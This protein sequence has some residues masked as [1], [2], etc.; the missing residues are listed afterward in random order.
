M[1]LFHLK[2]SF[3][4]FVGACCLLLTVQVG[5]LPKDEVPLISVERGVKMA[6]VALNPVDE[7]L[8][9]MT[10]KQKIGQMIQ[11][12]VNKLIDADNIDARAS[13]NKPRVEALAKLGIGSLFNTPFSG[14]NGRNTW[15]PD[16]W[17]AV[18][19]DIQVIFAEN[20]ALPVIYGIDTIHGANYVHGATLFPQPLAAASSFNVDL[21]YRMGVIEAKDS[22]AAGIPWVFSPVL[23]IAM[24]PKWSRNY[25]TFGEDPHT[26]AQLGVAAIRGIQ[27]NN[28]SAACMKHFIGYSN[29]TSGNDRADSV[30]NDFELLNYYAPPFLAAISEAKVRT[31]METYVS[32]NGEPVVASHKLLTD[33]LRIDMGFQGVLT[34]DENE[35]RQLVKEHHVAS[36]YSDALYSVYNGTS[37]DMNMLSNLS[38]ATTLTEDLVKQGLLTEAR[39]DESVRRILELKYDLGLLSKPTTV[40]EPPTPVGSVEDQQEAKALADESIILLKN[41]PK[42]PVDAVN[43]KTALPIEDPHATIFLTGPLADTKAFLCGGW[44]IY[45]QGTDNS[46]LIPHGIT[47]REGLTRSYDKLQYAKGVD[48]DGNPVENRTELLEK[49]AKSSYTIVVVGEAPYAEKNGDVDDL[50]LPEGQ[51]KYVQE[52]TAIKSTNV[53]LVIV[54]GRPRLLGGITTHAAAVLLSFLPC[55]QGG[56]AFTDIITGHVNPSGRLP[57][58]YPKSTGNVHLPYFHRVNTECRDS[59]KDCP[60]EWI[61]GSGLSYTSFDY[62][63]VTLSRHNVTSSGSLEVSMVVKNTGLRAGK[64]VVLLFISQKV[65]R[66]AVPEV[67]LL[68][69]FAK[70]S[71]QPQASTTVRF[72]LTAA[73]WSYYQPQI[74]KGFKSVVEPGIFHIQIKH[75]TDCK[76]DLH[77]CKAFRV[78]DDQAS[79]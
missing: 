79:S 53:I 43:P 77:L 6:A 7:I 28:R 49:A 35:I 27:S 63:D 51:R 36:S 72:T 37:I 22:L 78:L 71:L 10:L 69:R 46:S 15:T 76:K 62:R 9:K 44:S 64:E 34:T 4:V 21:V 42:L 70:V 23:G 55:E 66:G 57:M 1:T 14:W 24:H 26:V 30:I 3:A 56:Q 39:L 48:V 60:M 65:R 73:D 59:F 67:K 40:Y 75:D 31:A 33:L 5:R 13:L 17:R 50:L 54:A 11:V 25:E 12:D 52:L 45:W 38:D 61:F 74:G 18:L 2:A 32:V 29:P 16:E 41:E 47:I 68:K 8:R 20:G 19:N 58:T